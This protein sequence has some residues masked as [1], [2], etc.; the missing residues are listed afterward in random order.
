MNRTGAP[1]FASDQRNTILEM[2]RE[3][4][5]N[6]GGVQ[7]AHLIFDCHFTQCGSR[8]FE[9]ERM[10]YVVEHRLEPGQQYVTYYLVGEPDE[11]KPLPDYND[12]KRDQQGTN[13]SLFFEEEKP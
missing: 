4:R 2:L 3:A 12:C 6:G 5:L 8:I 1:Y 10:G 9:L 13:S 11:L 7:R